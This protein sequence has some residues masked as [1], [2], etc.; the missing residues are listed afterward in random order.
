MKK[1]VRLVCIFWSDFFFVVNERPS[2]LTSGLRGLDDQLVLA[3]LGTKS[4]L[5]CT[6]DQMYEKVETTLA[7]CQL[8]DY[9]VKLVKFYLAMQ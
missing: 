7:C 9:P 4:A 5:S 3:Y 2:K 6:T 1:N 8:W